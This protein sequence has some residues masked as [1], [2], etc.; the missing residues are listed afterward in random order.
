MVI[1]C[2][3]GVWRAQDLQKNTYT[4]LIMK[5]RSAYFAIVTILQNK[6]PIGAHFGATIAARYL[7]EDYIK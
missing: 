6:D 7:E 3:S 1:A 2:A 4:S 5:K